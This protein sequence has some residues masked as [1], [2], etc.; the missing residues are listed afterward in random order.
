MAVAVTNLRPFAVASDIMETVRPSGRQGRKPFWQ[1]T[2]LAVVLGS[3]SLR[4][5]VVAFEEVP[6]EV[7]EIATA[8]AVTVVPE[9]IRTFFEANLATVKEVAVAGPS[10]R[11]PADVAAD[12]DESHYIMLDVGAVEGGAEARRIA[13]RQFPHD[14]DGARKLFKR[15]GVRAG[16]LLPWVVQDRYRSLVRAFRV[17]DHNAILRA[18]GTLLRA[19]ADASLPFNT[20]ADR[21]GETSGNLGWRAKDAWKESGGHR[22]VRHRFHI[23]LIR[24]FRRQFEYEVRVWPSRFHHISEPTEATFE[25]LLDAH[26]CLPRLL[27]I[28]ADLVEQLDLT[29]AARFLA[30]SEA[31]YAHLLR[32]AGAA[33]ESRLEA[34]ALLGANLVG[35]AWT[36]AGSPSVTS[37]TGEV[38]PPV[39]AKPDPPRQEGGFVGSLNSTVFHR[40]DCGHA[41]RIRTENRV[42]FA[43][44]DTARAAG[45]IP[46]RVCRPDSP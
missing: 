2:A 28:D 22:T 14:Q 4:P 20:T 34:G 10:S 9:P 1:M 23:G 18:S 25:A 44:T 35:S 8:A 29:D 17:Q 43:T 30:S 42:H 13:A 38:T 45:R 7:Y 16:G 12:A 6:A 11:A 39:E 46:C 27:A 31:Y 3:L 5:A 36:E 24:R 33:M 15:H 40:I 21:D 19:A 32:R 41:K 37:L 26:A